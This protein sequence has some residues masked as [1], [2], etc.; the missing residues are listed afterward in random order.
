MLNCANLT[1]CIIYFYVLKGE[2]EKKISVATTNQYLI[3]YASNKLFFKSW[4]AFTLKLKAAIKAL[5]RPVRCQDSK[6]Q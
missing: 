6:F 3:F 1:A 2:K 5:T 4:V